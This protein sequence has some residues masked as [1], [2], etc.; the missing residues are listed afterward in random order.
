MTVRTITLFAAAAF[1]VL[2]QGAF[3]VISCTAGN[4]QST[5]QYWLCTGESAA[6]T[7][8]AVLAGPFPQH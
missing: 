1:G 4:A 3:G 5:G 2:A 7:V 6:A 8:A